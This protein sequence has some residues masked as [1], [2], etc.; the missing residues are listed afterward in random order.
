[1]VRYLRQLILCCKRD[2]RLWEGPHPPPM[3]MNGSQECCN[4]MGSSFS[5]PSPFFS[6][7][8]RGPMERMQ[9]LGFM[10]VLNV[11]SKIWQ[12]HHRALALHAPQR[13]HL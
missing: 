4:E 13:P 2:I 10:V 5:T 7:Y 12:A 6:C 1:M 8:F 3:G 11:G 9:L